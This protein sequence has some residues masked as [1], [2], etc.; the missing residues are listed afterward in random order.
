[1]RLVVGGPSANQ[2][3]SQ[4]AWLEGAGLVVGHTRTRPA[5]P[6]SSG[7]KTATRWRSHI[8]RPSIKTKADQAGEV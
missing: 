7:P 2:W 8:R 1:M 6:V 3:G 4:Q 5:V